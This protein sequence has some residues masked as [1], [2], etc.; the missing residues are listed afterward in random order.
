MAPESETNIFLGPPSPSKLARECSIDSDLGNEYI[1]RSLTDTPDC[2]VFFINEANLCKSPHE[3]IKVAGRIVI[4]AILD[5]RS[6]VNLL[7][8]RLYEE[9]TQSSVDI[10][11]LP[12]EHVVLV[13]AFGKR[14]KQ[15]KQQALIEF[16][17]GNELFESVFMVSSQLTNEAIISCQ[18]LK[19]YGVGINFDRGAFSYV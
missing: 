11:V 8:E 12:V 4:N 7:S 15:I 5:S 1:E 2:I 14:L 19:E 6:E 3:E 16:T 17:V 18:F 9:L 10:P 13:I